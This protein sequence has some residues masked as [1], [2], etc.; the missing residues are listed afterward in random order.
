MV[1]FIL[2]FIIGGFLGMS[3]ICIMNISKSSDEEA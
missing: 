3:I 2:G 1:K